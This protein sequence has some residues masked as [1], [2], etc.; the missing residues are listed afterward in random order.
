MIQH[1]Q[2]IEEAIADIEAKKASDWALENQMFFKRIQIRKVCNLVCLVHRGM[3]W[4][5]VNVV[6][7]RTRL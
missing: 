7:L 4:I 3:L 6:L 5:T 2:E 1:G